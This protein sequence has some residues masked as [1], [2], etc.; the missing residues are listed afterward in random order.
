MLDHNSHHR[1]RVS[2]LGIRGIPAAHGGFETFAARLAPYLASRGWQV[3]VYCQEEESAGKASDRL[4][5]ESD[6]EGVHC[7]HINIGTDNPFNSIRFDWKCITHVLSE[8]PDAVLILGYNTA[9]FA[10][11]LRSAGIPT[12]INMDGI[13]WARAKWSM[14]QKMWLYLNE[15]AACLLANHLIADHPQIESH[16][17]SRTHSRRITVI[18]YGSDLLDAAPDEQLL[19]R[20][21]VQPKRYATLIARPEPENSII[22][23]VRAFSAK[24]RGIKL[25]VLGKYFPDKVDYH[26][27]VLAAAGPEVKFIGAVYD[28]PLVNALRRNSLF[29]MH[30]HRVGGCNPSLL[31]AMGAGNPVLAHDNRFNRWVA[32]D[33]ALYFEDQSSCEQMLDELMNHPQESALRGELNRRRVR[34]VFNWNEI[35]QSYVE[36]LTGV[37]SKVPAGEETGFGRRAQ[38]RLDADSL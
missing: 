28:K 7:Y 22:E 27:K 31:E 8:R 36:L 26:A 37:S 35:L 11:R 14:T 16:L 10:A 9:L 4:T 5:W 25:L 13:E 30:G 23:M 12:V 34:N 29:Y 38:W 24:P 3:R 6:W 32:R 33:G 18:P 17:R 21:D 15:R 1:R 20:F 2:I 19:L